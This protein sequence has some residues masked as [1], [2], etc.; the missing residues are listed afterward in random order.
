MYCTHTVVTTTVTKKVTQNLLVE[1]HYGREC[2]GGPVVVVEGQI[3][4]NQDAAAK[5][6]QETKVPPA[7]EVMF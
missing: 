7:S 3:K 2:L 5:R 1:P 6:I 4:L